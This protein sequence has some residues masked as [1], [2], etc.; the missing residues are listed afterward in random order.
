MKRLLCICVLVSGL[1]RGEAASPELLYAT[2]PFQIYRSAAR[3]AVFANLRGGGFAVP[4]DLYATVRAVAGGETFFAAPDGRLEEAPVPFR[5][6]LVWEEGGQRPLGYLVQ[7]VFETGQEH[8]V[9]WRFHAVPAGSPVESPG[10]LARLNLVRSPPAALFVASRPFSRPWERFAFLR[11]HLA[12]GGI[13]MYAEV[14]DEGR[15]FAGY[16][17]PDAAE[18]LWQLPG[19]KLI[20][21]AGLGCDARIWVRD[22]ERFAAEGRVDPARHEL[23]SYAPLLRQY[24][25]VAFFE[26]RSAGALD[27]PEILGRLTE[28]MRGARPEDRIDMV[29]HSMGGM[30]VRCFV[31]LAEGHRVVDHAVLLQAPLNGVNPA[32][33]QGLARVLPAPFLAETLGSVSPL[34]SMLAGSSFYRRLNGPWE[35]GEPPTSPTGYGTCRYFCV[36]AGVHGSGS[37][38]GSTADWFDRQSVA[39]PTDITARSALWLPLGGGEPGELDP[40]GW[41]EVLLVSDSPAHDRYIEHISYVF[42]MGNEERNGSARWLLSRL[43]PEAG[44]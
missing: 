15:Q 27:G 31:E 28:A 39:M 17:G 34:S 13:S 5:R 14:L 22:F 1:V 42:H 36:A 7:P 19:P 26:Y 33:Y 2:F 38:P 43:W 9:E 40:T 3:S 10:A 35:R 20:L 44:P 32:P 24:R 8:V 4:V 30:V 16:A 29:G 12:E 25:Y 11:A 6:K 41:H 21:V 18:R 23:L 37:D